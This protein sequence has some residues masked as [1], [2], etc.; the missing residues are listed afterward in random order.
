VGGKKKT[1]SIAGHEKRDYK[2]G[3]TLIHSKG[4]KKGM[5]EREKGETEESEGRSQRENRSQLYEDPP[6]EAPTCIRETGTEGE[7]RILFGGG[8]DECPE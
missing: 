4:Q 1:I 3:C 8:E 6:P 2:K 5:Q 7:T